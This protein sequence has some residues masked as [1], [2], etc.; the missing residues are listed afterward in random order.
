MGIDSEGRT[1]AK[2]LYEF[3]ELDMSNYAKWFRKN[4][5]EN[6]FAEE[7]TDYWVFVPKDENPLGGRPTQD[8]KLTASFAKKLSMMQKNQKGEA[9]R[10]YFV[11]V[12]NGAKNL[13]SQYK[14]LSPTERPGEVANLIKVITRIMEKQGSAPCK[15]SENAQLICAQYGITL[16]SD[17]VKVPEYEQMSLDD[18]MK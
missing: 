7:N 5:L 3:L 14:A 9:A 13:I 6:D 16:S 10:N 1:T 4:I 11:G 15:V 17:F 2:K 18:F 12:E 8:A